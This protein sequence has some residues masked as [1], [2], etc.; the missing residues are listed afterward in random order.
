[1][2][3]V[4]K[5]EFFIEEYD[6]DGWPTDKYMSIKVGEVYEVNDDW[7]RVAGGYD[8]IR[9]ENNENGNWLELQQTTIDQYFDKIED[10]WLTEDNFEKWVEKMKHLKEEGE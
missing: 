10:K 8:T 9:L 6:D 7:H 1:M 2:K 3:Y 5:E 4:C